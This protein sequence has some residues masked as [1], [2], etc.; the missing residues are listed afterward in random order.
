MPNDTRRETPTEIESGPSTAG[1]MGGTDHTD[2]LR[3]S[4]VSARRRARKTLVH[5]ATVR[6]GAD[7]KLP[8]SRSERRRLPR[9]AKP[10]RPP[11][12]ENGEI[13]IVLMIVSM[14]V[15][16]SEATNVETAGLGE[17]R[18]RGIRNGWTR[19]R[20]RRSK[21]TLRRISNVGRS[22]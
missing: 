4:T 18:R 22:A 13:A 10:R 6:L 7:T 12:S 2:P 21:P 8:G 15:A 11:V 5:A 3:S 14:T 19:R 1:V 9:T 16:T 17:G 20:L